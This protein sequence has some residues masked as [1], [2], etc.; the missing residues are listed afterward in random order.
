MEEKMQLCVKLIISPAEMGIAKQTVF[1][2]TRQ[3]SETVLCQI[4]STAMWRANKMQNLPESLRDPPDLPSFICSVV[5]SALAQW[6][7]TLC[8]GS[9]GCSH[10]CSLVHPE[11]WPNRW[12]SPGNLPQ[13]VGIQACSWSQFS[14]WHLKHLCS[15]DIICYI[16]QEE[17]K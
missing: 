13:L 3:I 8:H 1:Y 16:E 15:W 9:T 2:F 4:T 11:T 7:V 5:D 14:G 6:P 10:T 12:S 17:R